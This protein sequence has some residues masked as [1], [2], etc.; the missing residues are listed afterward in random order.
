MI[1]KLDHFCK[2]RGEIKNVSNH[3]PIATKLSNPAFSCDGVESFH[4]LGK[5]KHHKTST[6][7][8]FAVRKF[9]CPGKK[10]LFC[11]KWNFIFHQIFGEFPKK[12]LG[13][14]NFWGPKNLG[15]IPFGVDD[16]FRTKSAVVLSGAP[17]SFS[18]GEFCPAL[19]VTW[20]MRKKGPFKRLFFGD[21]W[22]LKY[23]PSY[24]KGLKYS[25]S[26]WFI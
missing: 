19:W 9:C 11:T 14:P 15:G 5:K 3:H 10:I 1:V 21:V 25:T 2:D 22:G 18:G 7:T 24:K 17:N 4:L 20:T 23:Y 12:N 13:L 8:K 6:E 16:G 26:H